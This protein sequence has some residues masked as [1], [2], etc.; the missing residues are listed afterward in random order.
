MLQGTHRL[1]TELVLGPLTVARSP[2]GCRFITADD[3]YAVVAR[4]GAQDPHTWEEPHIIPP[5]HECWIP[6][7]GRSLLIAGHEKLSGRYIQFDEVEVQAANV[8]IAAQCE[9][10][11]MGATRRN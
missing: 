7:S 5:G 3:P 2:E 11:F 4:A 8:M 10:F 6:L 1:G 9:R